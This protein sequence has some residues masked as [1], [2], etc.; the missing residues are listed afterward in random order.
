MGEEDR[1]RDTE[2]GEGGGKMRDGTESI[3]KVGGNGIG[4]WMVTLGKE[5]RRGGKLIERL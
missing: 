4:L 2:D 1:A 5:G 3:L